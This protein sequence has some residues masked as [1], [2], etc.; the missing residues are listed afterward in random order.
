[1][2]CPDQLILMNSQWCSPLHSYPRRFPAPHSRKPHRAVVSK[3]LPFPE[4]ILNFHQGDDAQLQAGRTGTVALGGAPRGPVGA[5]QVHTA[6]W[7]LLSPLAH[8]LVP[9]QCSWKW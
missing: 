2:E 1:M 5:P 4:V 3:D 9:P 7:G 8:G 6:V